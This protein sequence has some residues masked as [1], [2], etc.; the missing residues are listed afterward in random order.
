MF[1]LSD[2]E[3]TAVFMFN[4]PFDEW[5]LFKLLVVVEAL[6]PLAVVVVVV[7]GLCAGFCEFDGDWLMTDVVEALT[8]A[9]AVATEA[10]VAAA[11]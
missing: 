5:L 1:E 10:I 2:N 6:L 9:E 8:A 4:E 3:S 11:V 7:E